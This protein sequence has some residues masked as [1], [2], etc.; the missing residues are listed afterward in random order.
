[1]SHPVRL[2]PFNPEF[3]AISQGRL[4]FD[5]FILGRDDGCW[6]DVQAEHRADIVKRLTIYRLRAKVTLGEIAD[7][8]REIYG[9]YREAGP[10]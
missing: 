1:M 8:L 10:A 2:A 7:T 3:T 4:L 6:L 9:E 5:L